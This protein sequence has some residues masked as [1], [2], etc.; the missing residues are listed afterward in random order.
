M[1][2]REV[3]GVLEIGVLE[4]N[5]SFCISEVDLCI[6]DALFGDSSV[7]TPESFELPFDTRGDTRPFWR[8][9]C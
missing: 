2:V 7:L 9:T 1:S 3:V 4:M 5:F 6:G 8:I